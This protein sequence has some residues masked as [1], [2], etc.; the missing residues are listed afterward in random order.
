M[1]MLKN[2]QVTLKFENHWVE[3]GL[4]NDGDV[5][6]DLVVSNLVSMGIEVED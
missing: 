1:N 5:Y 2:F 6:F 4:V 3:R